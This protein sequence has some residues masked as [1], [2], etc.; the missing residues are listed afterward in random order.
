MNIT[1]IIIIV[2]LII[3][4]LWI[5]S[6]TVFKTNIVMDLIT[7]CNIQGSTSSSSVSYSGSYS[8]NPNFVDKSIIDSYK[9]QNMMLSMWFYIES[10]D[11]NTS[12]GQKKNILY[13][14][15]EEATQTVNIDS[16]TFTDLSCIASSNSNYKNISV[17]LDDFENNLNIYVLCSPNTNNCT[18]NTDLI[19]SKYKVSNIPIQKWNNLTLSIDAKLLDV[20]LDGKLLN[21]FVLPNIIRYPKETDQN[22]YLGYVSGTLTWNGFITRIRFE[23]NSITP[24]DALNIYNAGINS[25]HTNS[26]LSKYS[27]KVSF[28]EYNKEKGSVT[29]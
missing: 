29:I 28:L 25:N 9:S 2:I 12:S 14:A 4:I 1:N 18:N 19:M 27:L 16:K 8:N 15:K 11:T 10:W 24:K 21:S 26:L 3:I 17:E 13:I 5:L 7:D 23:P 22:I 20:Y 6:S